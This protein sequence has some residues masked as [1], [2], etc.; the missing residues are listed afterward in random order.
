[1]NGIDLVVPFVDSSDPEWLRRYKLFVHDNNQDS[2][3]FRDTGLF[4]YFFRSVAKNIPWVDNIYL[5][6]QSSSQIPTWLVRNHPKLHIIYHEDYIPKEY[7]PTFNSMT[8]CSLL[9]LLR[10]LRGQFI[11]AD[12]DMIFVNKKSP[13]DFF[14]NGR[15]VTRVAIETTQYRRKSGVWNSIIF[16]TVK[17]F[18][19]VYGTR[20]LLKYKDYHLPLSLRKDF[21]GKCWEKFGFLIRE[22]LI[23]SRVRKSTNICEWIFNYAM[24]HEGLVVDNQNLNTNG[25]LG[26]EDNTTKEQIERVFEFSDIVC[27]NDR[28]SK[29]V[30]KVFEYADEVLNKLYPDKCEFE[31]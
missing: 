20:S 12:D 7:L 10:P 6:V 26:L 30:T 13:E 29:G 24:I 23:N 4:K 28:C 5:I 3:R 31:I 1:M 14:I 27:L 15:P 18:N 25:Y 17:L 21:I 22:Q 16:N 2:G 19:Q 11:L 9:H 8:I